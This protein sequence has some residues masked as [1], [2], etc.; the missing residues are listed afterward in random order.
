MRSQ[1][2]EKY[3]TNLFEYVNITPILSLVSWYLQCVCDLCNCGEWYFFR[4]SKFLLTPVFPAYFH[5]D[6]KTL[7]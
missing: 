7:L 1:T 3:N 4:G 6:F 2:E 5:K